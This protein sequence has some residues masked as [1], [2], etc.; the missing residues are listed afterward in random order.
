MNS[1]HLID[2]VVPGSIAEE[3]ELQKGDIIISINDN[4]VRDA[5][6][7]R[8]LCKDEYLSILI[9]R[10]EEQAVFEVE[11]DEDEDLGLLFDNGL[12][13][14]YHSCCNKCIFC[15]IDQ[16]PQ[17]MRETLYFKDD[18][19][20]LSF[21]QGNY[22]TLTNL[23]EDDIKRIIRYRLSPINISVHTMNPELRCKMLNNRFAGKSLKILDRFFEA[24]IT[25]NAQI[26]L[27]EGINDRDE[28]EYTLKRLSGYLP[29][30]ESV[31][32]VPVGLTKYRDGL[33]SLDPVSRE[34]AEHTIRIVEK[35]QKK[36]FP[37]YGLHFVHAS[38]EMYLLAGLPLPDE[39]TYD[40]YLQLENGVG[41]LT[42]LKNEFDQA[43]DAR[44]S[45][46]FFPVSG[47]YPETVVATGSL[48][49]PFIERL[50][51]KAKNVFPAINARVVPV[52]NDFFGEGVTV[53]GLVTGSDLLSQLSE[54]KPGSVVLIPLC[55]LRSG[56]NVFLDDITVEE[57]EYKLGIT[58]K[59]VPS[60]G[61]QLLDA[62]MYEGGFSK[63]KP[64]GSYRAYELH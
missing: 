60:D 37:S 21:L 13:D 64:S 59:T 10:G 12:M 48:A 7:Y 27:C 29:Y 30:L 42:L 41:M 3:L 17:G 47:S 54:I 33:K 38:D 45:K 53:A 24:G 28:L 49:A 1:G 46:D 26:V 9:K 15:F 11:K 16:M 25:M 23:K 55:M 63:G 36:L 18:D 20:R 19:A 14:D 57:I 34:N 2:G 32:V 61:A 43:L 62:L 56:E 44:V 52:R 39:E 31:S 51:E 4:P 22:I 5:L 35:W 40:G 6:D 8:F 58:V 50:I